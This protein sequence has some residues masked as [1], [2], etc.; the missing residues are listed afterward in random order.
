MIA[1]A[2]E[3][4]QTAKFR[5]FA[6]AQM[7]GARKA[8]L[9]PDYTPEQAAS[10]VRRRMNLMNLTG[11]IQAKGHDLRWNGAEE[12]WG[13]WQLQDNRFA[14]GLAFHDA[15]ETPCRSG[16]TAAHLP[17]LDRVTAIPRAQCRG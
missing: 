9:A 4:P 7:I 15:G 16:D 8:E 11:A 13:L 2:Q 5:I 6:T 14:R 1:K 12:A 3:D 10:M 17:Q